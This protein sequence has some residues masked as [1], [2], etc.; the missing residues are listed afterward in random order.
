MALLVPGVSWA[1]QI[2]VAN[3]GVSFNASPFAVALAKGFFQQAGADI[4]AVVSSPG[5]GTDVRM[6]L[7]GQLPYAESSLAGVMAAIKKGADL[8]IIAENADTAGEVNWV[9]MPGSPIKSLA[10]LRGKRIGYTNPQ[11]ASQ[12]FELLLLEK[13]GMTPNDVKMIATGGYGPALTA[14]EHDGIDVSP[15]SEPSYT[16]NQAKYTTVFR[17][18]EVFGSL[19]DG[20]A[21]TSGKMAR[22]R[23]E[24]IRAI[25]KA[26]RMAVDFMYSNPEESAQ[27]IA[28]AYN[29]DP[30][31]TE[32]IL[33]HIVEHASVGKVQYFG[34]GDFDWPG[35]N[36]MAHGLKLAGLIDDDHVDWS[37]YVDES[38]LPDD[39]KTP[40]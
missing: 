6:L 33:K 2:D 36:A 39:L 7:G 5:G 28:K 31:L 11:S 12:T 25:I 29:M 21:V 18:A 14:L 24:M 16:I 34:R 17:G 13:A 19:C 9:T 30:K 15:I 8:K 38:F 26:R 32:T 40:K 35:M 37:K 22:E 20:V 10:D 23:P 27:I 4:T 3:Y 1:E